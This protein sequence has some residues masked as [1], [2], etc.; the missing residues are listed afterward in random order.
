[1]LKKVS[2]TI[3]IFLVR[4]YQCGIAPLF[5]PVC[6]HQPSCSQYMIEAI[7]LWGAWNGLKLGVRRLIRCHPWGDQGYDPVPAPPVKNCLEERKENTPYGA[8]NL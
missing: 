5:P 2:A 3:M 6:R 8:T 7:T 4:L 1:M